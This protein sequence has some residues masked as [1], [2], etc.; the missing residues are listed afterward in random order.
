ME[1]GGDEYKLRRIQNQQL[2]RHNGDING[3]NKT[4]LIEG[5]NFNEKER[6]FP[7]SRDR[8]Q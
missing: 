6:I 2:I 7:V 8:S 4:N 5:L 3:L 1:V